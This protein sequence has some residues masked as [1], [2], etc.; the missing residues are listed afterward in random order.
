MKKKKYF[1]RQI[2]IEIKKKNCTFSC[3]LLF[4]FDD[5]YG[6]NNELNIESKSYN[7]CNY[8]N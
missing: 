8:L 6:Y 2:C 7:M 3:I 4:L 1:E 5:C